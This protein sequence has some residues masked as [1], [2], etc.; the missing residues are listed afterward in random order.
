MLL[1][2]SRVVLELEKQDVITKKEQ[3]LG[4][5]LRNSGKKGIKTLLQNKLKIR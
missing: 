4:L 1:V 3:H 5:T 2:L